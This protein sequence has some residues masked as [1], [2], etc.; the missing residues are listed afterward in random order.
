MRNL[1]LTAGAVVAIG[2]RALSSSNRLFDA[3]A[4][5]LRTFGAC[6]LHARQRRR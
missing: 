5:V 3:D 2:G 1:A 4:Q 6:F